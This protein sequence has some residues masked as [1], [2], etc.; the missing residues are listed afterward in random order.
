LVDPELE[1]LRWMIEEFRVQLFAQELGVRT[2]VSI[3]K[4]DEQFRKVRS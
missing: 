4:L 1:T 3:K 2:G